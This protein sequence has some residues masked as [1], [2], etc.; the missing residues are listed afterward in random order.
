MIVSG[1]ADA[2]VLFPDAWHY[3]MR[4]MEKIGAEAARDQFRFYL[5]PSLEH[6]IAE[7]APKDVTS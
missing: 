7:A 3:A 1:T 5:V 6:C 4:V 2:C